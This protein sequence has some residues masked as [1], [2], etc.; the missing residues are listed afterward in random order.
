MIDF[1]SFFF[2][3]L[4]TFQDFL[5]WIYVISATEENLSLFEKNEGMELAV[6]PSRSLSA[7]MLWLILFILCFGQKVIEGEKLCFLEKATSL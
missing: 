7:L 5:Q 2:A 6:Y 1:H 4:D 3:L